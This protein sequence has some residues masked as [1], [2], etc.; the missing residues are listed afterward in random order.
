M[1][2]RL[3]PKKRLLTR[4]FL[5]SLSIIALVGFG[6]A[7]MVN[8]LHV[9]NAYTEETAELIAEIPQVAAELREHD[10]IPDTSAWLEE[11]NKQENFVLASCDKDFKQVWTSKLAVDRGLF[12][13]C[14]QF[15]QIK[16]ESPPYHLT[17]SDDKGYFIYMLEVEISAVHYNLLIL[18]DAEQI[19]MEYSEF[20][21]RT[22]LRL[23]LVILLALLLLISAGYWGMRPLVR[24]QN[25]LQAINDG[26]NKSLSGGYPVELE[27]V[28]KALNQLLVQSN[29]QQQRYQ[30]AM[31][32]L[33]HS[34][35]T[36]LAAVHAITDDQS[37]DKAGTSE[38][39]MEQVSQM[40]L[41]VKYQL[42]RAMLGRKGLKT[43]MTPI[44]PLVAQLSQML[45]K[46][47]RDKN[48]RFQTDIQQNAMFPG[49]KGDLM[50]LCGNL[51]ENAF[52]LCISEV[53]LTCLIND[54]QECEIIVDDDGAGVEE[55][56][57]SKILQRGVRADRNSQGQGI[58]LAV[59]HEIVS[60][61]NGQLFIEDS[62]LQ[63]ARFRICI[64][65]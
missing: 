29:A 38:R 53:K 37:L 40:D 55:N 42:K 59:C 22:Y 48:I 62:D 27:G 12:D 17:L 46:V 57:R 26:K 14:Q 35:K 20:S 21:K 7:W 18:K 54:A 65:L 2:L 9:Q 45:F 39:I 1:Q 36:R 16:D 30:N 47:Y 52:R 32:D 43:E 10:L 60:S 24:M 23:A 4:M 13:T 64:P 33:A 63:G 34:L 58:G 19:E 51:M 15:L 31:N 25:E 8:T 5:T 61:Y 3:K 11:N 49:D 44:A 41:L 50:E 28:T 56:M 6:L